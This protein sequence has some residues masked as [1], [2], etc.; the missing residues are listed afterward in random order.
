MSDY[1]GSRHWRVAR[2]ST[3]GS[4]GAAAGGAFAGV[5]DD[6]DHRF[7]NVYWASRVFDTLSLSVAAEG[8]R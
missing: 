3:D 8:I 6:F 2:G 4:G 1:G 7:L 5:P